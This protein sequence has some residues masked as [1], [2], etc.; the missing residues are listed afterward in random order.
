MRTTKKP[1]IQEEEN[2]ILKLFKMILEEFNFR[3]NKARPQESI[4]GEILSNTKKL[5]F[6]SLKAK[7]QVTQEKITQ[8]IYV[9]IV[10]DEFV[11]LFIKI[12]HKIIIKQDQIYIYN[13]AFWEPVGEKTIKKTLFG[14]AMLQGVPIYK[15]K[16]HSFSQQLYKQVLITIITFDFNKVEPNRINLQNC[17]IEFSGTTASV[18][19]FDQKHFLRYQ[20]SFCFDPQAKAPMFQSYLDKVLPDNTVQKVL[21]EFIGSVFIKKDSGIKLEKAL[22]LFGGG[23]NGKSV[24]FEIIQALLGSNNISNFSLGSLTDKTGYSRAQIE[25]KLLNFASEIDKTMNAALFKQLASNEPVEARHIYGR[26]HQ[27]KNYAK[28]AFNTNVLPVVNDNTKAFFRRFIIVPFNVKISEED[29]DKELHSKIIENEL[30]GVFNWV[31]EGLKRVVENKG[32]T[33]S[34]IID[35]QVRIYQTE[36]DTVRLFILDKKHTKS[37][38]FMFKLKILFEEY[39]YFCIENGYKS[40]NN[41][42]FSKALKIIGFQIKRKNYGR[43][44]NIHVQD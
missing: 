9:V 32:F 11:K 24:F 16:H 13:G 8:D 39:K 36:S 14:V 42:D 41:L 4:F 25:D 19:E 7:Y 23:S 27:I 22:V 18:V 21:A 1:S 29:Q 37:I 5:D 38:K 20:L 28:L 12:N 40:L 31:I 15:A 17:T 33:Q 35:K 34:D 3:I 10:V 44:V 26:P 43:V 2:L 6:D 30:A